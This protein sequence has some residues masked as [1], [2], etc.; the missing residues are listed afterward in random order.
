M[1]LHYFMAKYPVSLWNTLHYEKNDDFFMLSLNFLA[2]LIILKKGSDPVNLLYE[3]WRHIITGLKVNCKFAFAKTGEG[4]QALTYFLISLDWQACL[5]FTMGNNAPLKVPFG[6]KGRKT[7]LSLSET[8]TIKY[9]GYAGYYFTLLSCYGRKAI[10]NMRKNSDLFLDTH[11]NTMKLWWKQ[12]VLYSTDQKRRGEEKL[13]PL[14]ILN[15][16]VP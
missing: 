1:T 8:H 6:G 16:R 3:H 5:Y 10:W 4:V 2:W 14:K 12:K 9:T 15:V 11:F 7:L 13:Q